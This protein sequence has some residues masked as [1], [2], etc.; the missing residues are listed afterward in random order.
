MKENLFMPNSI[1]TYS[2][3]YFDYLKMDPD[4]IDINDIAHA[5]SLIPRWLG[6]T[7][8]LYSVAQHCCWCHDYYIEI[9]E[10]EKL[11]RL[12]HDATEAYLG[13]CPSP[14]KKLLPGY[15]DLENKL[16]KV[17]AQ[18]YGYNY[19]YSS[20]TKFI[21]LQALHYEWEFIRLNDGEVDCWTSEKAEAE[22]LMRFSS[23]KNI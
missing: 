17:L 18:K 12:M 21:D 7:A 10:D 1:K 2:G 9:V 11:E 6:H 23:L 5:L 3:V 16:S 22:F 4:T 19:P 8:E 15:K 14:L 13:D 20:T